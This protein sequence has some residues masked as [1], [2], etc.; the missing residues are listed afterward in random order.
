MNFIKYF[1]NCCNSCNVIFHENRNIFSK[2]Q[3]EKIPDEIFIEI[4]KYLENRDLLDLSCS[5]ERFYNIINSGNG[6]N[7]L[8][9]NLLLNI[10]KTS[11]SYL[12]KTRNFKKRF[13]A[14]N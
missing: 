3:Y 12:N 4:F 7:E 11:N 9:R 5:C 2:E 8:Y 10:F 14:Y 6:H 1:L 13:I